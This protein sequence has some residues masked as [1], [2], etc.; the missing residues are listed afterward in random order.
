MSVI[1]KSGSFY[2]QKLQVQKLKYSFNSWYIVSFENIFILHIKSN[3]QYLIY[4]LF[5][6]KLFDLLID[7]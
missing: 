4:Q 3:N 2:F 6:D 1:F 7:Y 5:I